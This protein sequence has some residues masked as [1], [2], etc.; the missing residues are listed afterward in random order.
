MMKELRSKNA[1]RVGPHG[2]GGVL[3]GGA[4]QGD[5]NMCLILQGEA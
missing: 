2:D 5:C 3:E 4:F 1:H